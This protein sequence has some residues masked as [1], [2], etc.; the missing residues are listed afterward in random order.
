M[1][2]L[3]LGGRV[4]ACFNSFLRDSTTSSGTLRA[5]KPTSIIDWR[6]S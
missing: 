2:L 3:A 4:P 1:I 5:R 6:A